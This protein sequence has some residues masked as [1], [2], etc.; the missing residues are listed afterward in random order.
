MIKIILFQ[1]ALLNRKSKELINRRNSIRFNKRLS[2]CQPL[3]PTQN[4]PG[5]PTT[6]DKRKTLN[7]SEIIEPLPPL[8]LKNLVMA[9]TWIE[10]AA[11]AESKID[12]ILEIDQENKAQAEETSATSEMYSTKK[13]SRKNLNKITKPMDKLQLLKEPILPLKFK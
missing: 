1:L 6:T 2:K 10:E 13:D 4:Q 8:L 5:K 9:I 12:F 11:Q 3:G 7:K